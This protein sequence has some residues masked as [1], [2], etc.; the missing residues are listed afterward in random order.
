MLNCL[1]TNIGQCTLN[2]NLTKHGPTLWA[3][4]PSCSLLLM[5]C[6]WCRK[7]LSS[8]YS[9]IPAIFQVVVFQC[10]S[11]TVLATP[12]HMKT[13][14]VQG[15]CNNALFLSHSLFVILRSSTVSWSLWSYGIEHHKCRVWV[16]VGGAPI[17]LNLELLYI[18]FQVRLMSWQSLNSPHVSISSPFHHHPQRL[19]D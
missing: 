19:W 9:R 18:K 8:L 7:P 3:L 2:C 6:V 12:S 14:T 17:I 5:L 11:T 16:R 10:I 13:Y 1:N 4:A 15:L